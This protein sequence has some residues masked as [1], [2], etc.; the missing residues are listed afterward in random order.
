MFIK[1]TIH[2]NCG[3]SFQLDG[4]TT[5]E[6]IK[7]PNCLTP[8]DERLSEKILRV[9]HDVA[10]LPDHEFLSKETYVSLSTSIADD[11]MKSR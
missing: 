3:C 4:E 10:E 6:L 5:S 8:L 9:L 2:C 11:I 1:A 7:C